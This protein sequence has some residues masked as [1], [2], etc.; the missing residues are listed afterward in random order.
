KA[1]EQ[2]LYPSAG[3]DDSRDLHSHAHKVLHLDSIARFEVVADDGFRT[4]AGDMDLAF[5]VVDV[6]EEHVP[7]GL[8]VDADRLK[9]LQ[10]AVACSLKHV[11]Q[12]PA[13]CAG[14]STRYV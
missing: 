3:R 5:R 13:V 8:T 1:Q 9:L 4:D 11:R 10:D 7:G 14:P 6:G 2:T 12:P